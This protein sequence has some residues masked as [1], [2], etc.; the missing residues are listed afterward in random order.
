MTSSSK[1]CEA[2]GL[3][4]RGTTPLLILPPVH[5]CCHAAEVEFQLP[6]RCHVQVGLDA[7][8]GGLRQVQAGSGRG[9]GPAE[10]SPPLQ[11]FKAPGPASP[12][13]YC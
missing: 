3:L 5:L 9:V 12:G 7:D 10:L 1:L 13:A 6:H 8:A 2:E 11:G 4:V